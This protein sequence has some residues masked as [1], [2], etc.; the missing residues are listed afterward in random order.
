MAIHIPS[1]DAP[2]NAL[3]KMLRKIARLPEG[4]RPSAFNFF[5]GRF[6]PFYAHLRVR[7]VDVQPDHV[8]LALRNTKRTRN[9]LRGIHAIAALL[10]AEYAAGLV[11]GQTVP[12]EAIVVVRGL[13]CEIRKP[14]KGDITATAFLTEDQ[15]NAL[16]QEPKGD[17]KLVFTITGSDGET[18]ITG[19][20]D[21]AWFP[22]KSNR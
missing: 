8:T 2:A 17:I 20:A 11:V 22:R 1:P 21:M 14:I 16:S 9:H 4:M 12:P 3:N 19:V 5:F 6:T 15:R 10:P 18:P 13:S 7:A